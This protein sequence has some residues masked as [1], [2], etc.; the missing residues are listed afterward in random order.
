M[1]RE[2]GA[3]RQR[4]HEFG[5]KPRGYISYLLNGRMHAIL[6]AEDRIHSSALVPTRDEKA[7]LFDTMIAYAGRYSVDGDRIV[8]DIEMSWNELWT[9]SRQLRFFTLYGDTLTITTAAGPSPRDGRE[10]RSIVI[11]QKVCRHGVQ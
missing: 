3:V 1:V 11:L 5:S 7:E 2:T 4:C 10:G 8:H 6:T 9:G